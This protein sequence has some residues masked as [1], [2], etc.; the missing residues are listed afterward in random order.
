MPAWWE[1]AAPPAPPWPAVDPANGMDAAAAAVAAVP[2]ALLGPLLAAFRQHIQPVVPVLG[3]DPAIFTPGGFALLTPLLQCA[4]LYCVAGRLPG[5]PQPESKALGWPDFLFSPL[6]AALTAELGRPPADSLSMM[7]TMQALCLAYCGNLTSGILASA[8]RWAAS[9]GLSPRET[10]RLV[11][12]VHLVVTAAA[13]RYVYSACALLAGMP[14]EDGSPGWGEA[15]PGS[16]RG[17]RRVW[18]LLHCLDRAEAMDC[19]H[20][21]ALALPHALR[22]DPAPAFA[23]LGLDGPR[24]SDVFAALA[25]NDDVLLRSL[26]LQI[27]EDFRPV[28]VYNILCRAL[29]QPDPDPRLPFGATVAPHAALLHRVVSSLPRTPRTYMA[30]KLLSGAILLALTSRTGAQLSVGSDPGRYVRGRPQ[31][32][33]F[34]FPALLERGLQQLGPP[35]GSPADQACLAVAASLADLHDPEP[36]FF[37]SPEGAYLTSLVIFAAQYRLARARLAVRTGSFEARVGFGPEAGVAY[38]N[39]ALKLL[40]TTHVSKYSFLVDSVRSVAAEVS[41]WRCG[42]SPWLAIREGNGCDRDGAG[43]DVAERDVDTI[44]GGVASFS[45][46]Y[47]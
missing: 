12:E 6:D 3:P 13:E 42:V 9:A 18:V 40:A 16:A 22:A 47:V 34:R 21:P 39:R 2:P 26:W 44:Y 38:A 23:V 41:A 32:P 28:V 46:G 20:P 15:A 24:Y 1:P 5:W 35:P 33:V 11:R 19:N 29:G 31:F 37:A 14:V 7:Y 30:L 36:W 8:A 25:T 27:H 45:L 10:Q 43:A 4:M 17:W